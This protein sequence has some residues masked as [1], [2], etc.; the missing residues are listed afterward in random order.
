MMIPKLFA[1]DLDGT[2]LNSGKRVSDANIAALREI[3]ASGARVALA[4]GRL[5]AGVRRYASDI[6]FDPAMVVLNGAEVFTASGENA[7]RVYYEPLDPARAK[8]L[9]EYGNNKPVAVNF[10]YQDK[11]YAVK[12][13]HNVEW[14]NLYTK[15][16]GVEYNFLD[17]FSVMS[18]I[19]PSKVIFIG[20]PRYI[21]GQEEYFRSLWADG[22]VYVCRSWDYYLEFMNP[23]ATKGFG[24]KAL[25]M[26]F[27]VGIE[28][29]VAYGDAEN[30]IPM[31]EAAG[32]GVAMKNAPDKVKGCADRVT[33]LTNDEDWVALEWERWRASGGL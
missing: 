25:C 7:Q 4:S 26:A 17:D 8:Y 9:T 21:D 22:S 2:L 11:L 19:S 18:G 6:G 32:T 30:D 20:D 14:T 31:L 10:Y 12:S 15:E 5:G 3:R 23:K 33:E 13:S 29:A 1:F 16:T 28:E 27:G 24:L